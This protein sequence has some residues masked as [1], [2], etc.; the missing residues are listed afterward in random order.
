MVEE[1][2][3]INSVDRKTTATITH[4]DPDFIEIVT[5]DDTAM[6][7]DP[8]SFKDRYEFRSFLKMLMRFDER[9]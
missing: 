7:F 3:F 4:Y 8:I 6:G 9:L 5:S 2:K 1:C